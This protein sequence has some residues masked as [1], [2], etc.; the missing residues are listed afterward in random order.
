MAELDQIDR[1]ILAVL[2]ENA[3]LPNTALADAV[4]L[5]PSACLRRVARLK[6]TGVIRRIVALV[7]P[8]RLN[9][10]LSAIVTVKFERHGPEFRQE[11]VK[12]V[13]T[14]PAISQCYMVTGDV[15][16]VL[17]LH[18][19]DMDEYTA[20]ADR[21]FHADSNVVAFTT[22]FVLDTQKLE[23]SLPMD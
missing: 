20:L 5:S 1:R 8:A 21:L 16:C 17:V 14:E 3:D 7:D 13:Q 18:A 10:R 19:V 11:F 22:H 9:R 12:R 23:T 15:S 6:E 2:R 4:G